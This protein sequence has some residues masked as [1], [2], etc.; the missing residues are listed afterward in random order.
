MFFHN[1]FSFVLHG[2]VLFARKTAK[3]FQSPVGKSRCV[4]CYVFVKE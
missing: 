2:G 4:M 3:G 1:A